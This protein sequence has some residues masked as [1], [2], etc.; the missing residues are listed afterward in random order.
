M[1]AFNLK[2]LDLG[3]APYVLYRVKY[4]TW[5]VRPMFCVGLSILT[6]YPLRPCQVLPQGC[7]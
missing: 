3:R 4:I 6:Q 2:R 5:V 7:T 1:R